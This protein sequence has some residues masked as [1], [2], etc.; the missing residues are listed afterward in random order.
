MAVT[1]KICGVKDEATAEFAFASGAD[2]VGL[3]LAESPRQVSV[4][5]AAEIARA[6]A[7]QYVL[8]L[9]DPSDEQFLE[10]LAVPGAAY[11]QCHGR[12]VP[13]WIDAV[14]R[15]GKRAIATD[16][17]P[18]ADIILL[19]GPHPGSGV[20]REWSRPAL[21]QPVWLAG[22][23]AP[24]NVRDV[25]ARLRP[26]GVDVSS[27]VERQGQKDWGLIRR[28]IEEAKAWQP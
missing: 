12:L 26:D 7:G 10:A 25:V 20:P 13:N 23:L 15:A 14:R 3:V 2:F 22:G 9:K 21:A 16:I 27:G 6:V 17:D 24:D 5:R 18:A 1:V 4:A 11:V 19:D 8:V 28:F